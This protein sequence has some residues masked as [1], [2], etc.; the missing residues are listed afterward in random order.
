MVPD[1]FCISCL[2]SPFLEIISSYINVWIC[3]TAA[4]GCSERKLSLKDRLGLNKAAKQPRKKVSIILFVRNVLVWNQ[5]QIIKPQNH[6]SRSPTSSMLVKLST[7]N[8]IPKIST[9]VQ[10]DARPRVRN[11]SVLELCPKN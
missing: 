6:I 9:R 5:F 10:I 11:E 2:H 4:N 3:F 7:E 8:R 1:E